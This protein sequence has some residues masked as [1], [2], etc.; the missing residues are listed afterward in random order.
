M[1]RVFLSL[2]IALVFALLLV[3]CA[4]QTQPVVKEA[5]ST[6]ADVEA[7]RALCSQWETAVEAGD[8]DSL[9]ALYTDDA[10][11]LPPGGPSYSGKAAFEE[12]YRSIFETFSAEGVWPV[13]G[14]EEIIV[15]GD[16]AFHLSEYILFI[17]TNEGGETMEENGKI[18][19]IVQK[20]P[21]GSWKFAR[22]IWNTTPPPEAE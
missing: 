5:A 1:K 21:D 20:Q 9:L 6:E 13:E 7:I 11:R 15:A 16:W 19:E 10:V 12:Y 17:T 2:G 18:V 3:T 14:T 22:E 4:P 8:I